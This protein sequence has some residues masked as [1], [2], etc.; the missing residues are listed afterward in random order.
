MFTVAR[1]LEE[2]TRFMW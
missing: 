2:F 1:A